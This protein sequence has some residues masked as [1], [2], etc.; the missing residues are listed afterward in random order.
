MSFKRSFDLDVL[1]AVSSI[2]YGK[3]ATYGQIADLIGAYGCA[4]QVGWSLRRLP[5]P[6]R[7]P[8]YRVVNARGMISTSESREG[9]DWIQKELLIVEGIPVDNKWRVPL[10]KYLWREG[11]FSK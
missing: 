7:V 5:L 4:R 6:S 2:P 8:W 9:T 1:E 3:L 11:T 10:Q